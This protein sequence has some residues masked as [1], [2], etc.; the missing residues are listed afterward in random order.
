[1]YDIDCKNIWKGLGFYMI[2]FIVGIAF[3]FPILMVPADDGEAGLFI[4][5]FLILPVVFI[6]IGGI[7]IIKVFKRVKQV[8]RLNQVG[9]LYK[10]IPYTLAS[11]GMSV[12]DVPILKPVVKFK[13]PNGEFVTLSGDARHD[14]KDRDSDGYI[15]LVLDPDNYDNYFLDYDINRLGGN[16]KEDYYK[17]FEELKREQEERI[18]A[19]Q[20]S[21][22][23]YQYPKDFTFGN[24]DN[25][26]D[27][28]PYK[29]L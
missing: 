5:M 10:N 25:S 18:A 28:R 15:D 3:L 2:F 12:N 19:S 8:K 16:R 14:R 26:S 6:L 9:V 20:T 11:T 13:L 27:G 29:P 23:T 4:L 1:M 24:Y 17:T 21:K 22:N 7:N